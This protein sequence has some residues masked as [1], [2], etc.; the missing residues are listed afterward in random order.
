MVDPVRIVTPFRSGL[1]M[2]LPFWEDSGLA[3]DIS[4]NNNYGTPSQPDLLLYEDNEAFWTI[5]TSGPS[6]GAM[7]ISAGRETGVVHSG[8]D[9]PIFKRNNVGY[10]FHAPPS[11]L[12]W[13]HYAVTYDGAG[14]LTRYK[15]GG[16]M[17][18]DTGISWTLG[19]DTTPL[20]IGKG[21]NPSNVIMDEV[22]IFN[23]ALSATEVFEEF[24]ITARGT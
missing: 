10:G 16:Y 7:D 9:E 23:R 13:A 22:K 4:R 21:D 20:R 18:Q 12:T 15:N 2:Y 8:Q 17:Y 19:A 24:Y 3:E 1:V 14:T 11:L 5:N 6:G